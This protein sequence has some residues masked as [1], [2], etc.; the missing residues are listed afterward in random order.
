MYR[1]AGSIDS[2][3]LFSNLFEFS[4]R[5]GLL[6]GIVRQLVDLNPATRLNLRNLE[7]QLK[8]VY[9]STFEFAKSGSNNSDLLHPCVFRGKEES[10]L[11]PSSKL[12]STLEYEGDRNEFRL[13]R[14][15]EMLSKVSQESK[16]ISP[17]RRMSA[18]PYNIHNRKQVLLE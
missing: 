7:Q 11:A 9:E 15:T 18:S 8:I 1:V 5:Y 10:G 14:D 4:K 6:N 2:K 3:I 17:E 16:S 12:E 13:S